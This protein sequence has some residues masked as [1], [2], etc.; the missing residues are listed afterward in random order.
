M[1]YIVSKIYEVLKKKR[2]L[3]DGKEKKNGY[4]NDQTPET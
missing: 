1:L 3:H 4:F 2:N